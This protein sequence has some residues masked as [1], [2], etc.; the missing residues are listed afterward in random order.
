MSVV[1]GQ[2]SH[3]FETVK[4]TIWYH[5]VQKSRCTLTGQLTYKVKHIKI[6]KI[7]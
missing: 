7:G 4:I 3:A 2:H 6:T 1:Y 5:D